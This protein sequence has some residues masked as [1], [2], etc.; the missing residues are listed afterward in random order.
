[1]LDLADVSSNTRSN[2]SFQL[3]DFVRGSLIRRAEEAVGCD[4]R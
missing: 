2:N 4:I 3:E 1:M